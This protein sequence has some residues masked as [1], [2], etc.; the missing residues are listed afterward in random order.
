[1]KMLNIQEKKFLK[2]QVIKELKTLK[3]SFQI[4]NKNCSG[5]CVECI[6]NSGFKMYIEP[7]YRYETLTVAVLSNKEMYEN[8]SANILLFIDKCFGTIDGDFQIQNGTCINQY[9]GKYKIFELKDCIVF[10]KI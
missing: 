3:K 10:L 9:H 5:F 8:I 2:S 6:G 1:M 4:E 7:S